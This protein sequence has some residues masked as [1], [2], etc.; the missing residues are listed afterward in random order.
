MKVVKK[1]LTREPAASIAIS[2]DAVCATHSDQGGGPS[3]GSGGESDGG[4]HIY[5]NNYDYA[6]FYQ[7]QSSRHKTG[8]SGRSDRVSGRSERVYSTTTGVYSTESDSGL[9]VTP[10]GTPYTSRPESELLL[11]DDKEDKHDE[12]DDVQASPRQL[13]LMMMQRSKESEN[14]NRCTDPDP[15]HRYTLLHKM[16]YKYLHK[17]V[18]I[19]FNPSSSNIFLI[20]SFFTSDNVLELLMNL[21]VS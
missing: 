4:Q 19:S 13:E 7:V 1:K 12:V 2:C 6:D 5:V 18:L 17:F 21:S 15:T 11:G 3:G 10:E 9:D 14:R 8:A 20:H 16:Y